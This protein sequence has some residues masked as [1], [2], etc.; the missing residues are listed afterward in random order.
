[1]D[2]QTIELNAQIKKMMKEYN[3]IPFHLVYVFNFENYLTVSDAINKTVTKMDQ[4]NFLHRESYKKLSKYIND[5]CDLDMYENDP[6]VNIENDE[7]PELLTV[8]QLQD[9]I[10]KLNNLRE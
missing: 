8:D 9:I 4:P 5:L 7:K 3:Y 1:M 2:Q 6:L 10:N